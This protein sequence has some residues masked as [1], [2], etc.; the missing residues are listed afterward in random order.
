MIEKKLEPLDRLF[1]L[2]VSMDSSIDYTNALANDHLKG[3]QY[4]LAKKDPVIYDG[5]KRTIKN[6]LI[7]P[8]VLAFKRRV[9]DYVISQG[10][11]GDSTKFDNLIS[12]VN[13]RGNIWE[14]VVYWAENGDIVPIL[15]HD[16]AF[17]KPIGD[18]TFKY[19]YHY[20]EL[21]DCLK[22]TLRYC[23]G[24]EIENDYVICKNNET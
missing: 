22:V 20:E 17:D 18:L 15:S 11:E 9:Y 21:P 4:K 2:N 16:I 19:Y 13:K 12:S 1:N 7:S 6:D 8:I 5:Y 3:K 14:K 10:I 24:F 23:C